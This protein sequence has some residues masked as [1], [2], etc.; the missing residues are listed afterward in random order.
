MNDELL[1]DTYSEPYKHYCEVLSVVRMYYEKDSSTV[2]SFILLVE[3]HRGS[4]AVQRLRNEA[5]NLLEK[6]NG[7]KT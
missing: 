4:T 7:N 3:K 2:K 5:L 6:Q 1:T